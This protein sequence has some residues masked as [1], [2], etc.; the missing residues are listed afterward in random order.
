MI[1][2]NVF[3][4]SQWQPGTRNETDREITFG[5]TALFV[6]CC[7]IYINGGAIATLKIFPYVID[8]QSQA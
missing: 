1:G 2:A 3:Y 6:D 7:T 8:S 4:F 5:K